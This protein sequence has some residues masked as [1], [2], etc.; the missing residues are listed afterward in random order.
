M[1][2]IISKIELEGADNL[3]YSDY[4]TTT[5]ENIVNQINEDYDSTLGAFLGENRTKLQL[6]IVSVSTF[7]ET[8]S[9]VYEARTEVDNIEGLNVLNVTDLNQL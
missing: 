8:T 3:I 5:D 4:G 1:Y 6:G 9:F 7:F 2:Y